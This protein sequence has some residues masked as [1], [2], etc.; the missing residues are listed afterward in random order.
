M[1]SALLAVLLLLGLTASAAE[2]PTEPPPPKASPVIKVMEESLPRAGG[3]IVFGGTSGLGLEVVKELVAKKLQVTV[4]ARATSDTA[5]AKALG[6]EVVEG[7]ALDA[8]AVK[9]AFTSAPFRAVVSTLGG[10]DGDYRVDSQGNKNVIDATKNA[11][12][13]RI[14]LVTALGAG[15][16]NAGAPWYIKLFMGD[17]FA[18]KTE[19]ENHLTAS[20]LDYT[21]V[22]PGVLLDDGTPG[23]SKFVP[24]AVGITGIKRSE[25]AKLVAATVDD[26]GSYKK[27]YAAIDAKRMGLWALLTY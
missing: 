1:R 22:R 5:A 18:A 20:G 12:L 9:K 10:R 8:D 17:Y 21:I 6:A 14:I 7:D 15:D 4:V 3:V 25:L 2:D 24:A 27:T 11:G 26:L 16:S 19:A 13:E 23:E